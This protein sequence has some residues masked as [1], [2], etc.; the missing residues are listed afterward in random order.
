MWAGPNNSPLMNGTL[1]TRWD[2][3]SETGLQFYCSF[4]LR[5]SFPLCPSL[6]SSREVSIQWTSPHGKE[7][8]EASRP[9]PASNWGSSVQRPTRTWTSLTTTRVSSGVGIPS[10]ASGYHPDCKLSQRHPVKQHPNI[11]PR[12]TVRYCFMFS[13]SKFWDN[14]LNRAR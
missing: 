4:P 10:Q 9:Q 14:L 13:I 8:R 2:G 12:G 6:W 7:L 11:F 3:S 5:L 1:Q